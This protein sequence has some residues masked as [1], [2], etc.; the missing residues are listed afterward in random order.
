MV[1]YRSG[2]S[3]DRGGCLKE[4][5]LIVLVLGF[6]IMVTGGL[7]ALWAS[8]QIS[9]LEIAEDIWDPWYD[10][11]PGQIDPDFEEQKDRYMAIRAG[12]LV[13][14][15]AGI[16]VAVYGFILMKRESATSRSSVPVMSTISGAVNFCEYCGRQL[17]PGAVRCPAC[18]RAFRHKEKE[19]GSEQ[20]VR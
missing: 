2:D 19:V 6:A 14:L 11:Y 7:I 13:A 12:G 17:S 10:S 3:N 16:I 5:P 9:T 15:V 1:I 18:G 20:E 4:V 8:F